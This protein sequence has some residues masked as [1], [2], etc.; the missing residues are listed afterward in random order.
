MS[1]AK[2][3]LSVILVIATVGMLALGLRSETPNAPT[4]HPRYVPS[5][6]SDGVKFRAFNMST[7]TITLEN[8]LTNNHVVKYQYEI[9][10]RRYSFVS[11]N[12]T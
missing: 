9:D 4:E 2:K 7:G 1:K 3:T 10:N 8:L 12:V 6:T 11:V 5:V